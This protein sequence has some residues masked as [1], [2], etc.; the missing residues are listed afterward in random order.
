MSSIDSPLF[1]KIKRE[2]VEKF[3]NKVKKTLFDVNK[4]VNS[5]LTE[6]VL[7]K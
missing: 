3:R 6:K 2:S 5:N 4:I 7:N 1:P